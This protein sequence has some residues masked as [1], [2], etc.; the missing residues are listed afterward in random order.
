MPSEGGIARIANVP[1][2]AHEFIHGLLYLDAHGRSGHSAYMMG[3]ISQRGFWLFYP[4]ALFVK[5]P[6]L[7]LFLIVAGIGFLIVG[8]RDPEWATFAGYALGGGALLVVA[9]F[10][11]INLGLRHVLVVYPLL[12]MAG[13]L[14]LVRALEAMTSRSMIAIVASFI[15]VGQAICLAQSFPNQLA[16]FNRFAGNDPGWMLSDSDLEWG[17]DVLALERYFAKHPVDHVYFV[18]NGSALWCRHT[19]P[20]LI[21]LPPTGTVDGWIVVFERPYRL[22]S[23]GPMIDVCGNPVSP[24]NVAAVDPG[25]LDWLHLREPKAYVG[26]GV[27]IYYVGGDA[28][29]QLP[30]ADGRPNGPARSF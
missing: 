2:P 3:K 21:P 22:N 30:L 18:G 27:R 12:A 19:L 28:W 24:E 7:T 11:P 17:Q 9:A 15:V 4:V 26:A 13:A 25:W 6:P 29:E 14:G 23:R 20:T 16:Y 1:L 8:R 5:T 10:N